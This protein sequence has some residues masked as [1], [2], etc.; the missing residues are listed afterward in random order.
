MARFVILPLASIWKME[1]YERSVEKCGSASEDILQ[2]QG[3][4]NCGKKN[5]PPVKN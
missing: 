2:I 4:V 5:W 1:E 3:P